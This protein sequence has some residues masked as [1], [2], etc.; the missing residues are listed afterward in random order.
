[1]RYNFLHAFNE[2]QC[3]LL[4]ALLVRSIMESFPPMTLSATWEHKSPHVC[5][6]FVCCGVQKAFQ[7]V[8]AF[9][10]LIGIQDVVRKGP[11]HRFQLLFCTLHIYVENRRYQR[12]FIPCHV[13]IERKHI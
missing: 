2:N 7:F 13:T 3:S 11:V 8:H 6:D 10:I 12:V 1:M 4:L 5:I 9:S